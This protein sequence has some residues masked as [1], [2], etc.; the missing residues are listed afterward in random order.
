M[1]N[2]ICPN[3]IEIEEAACRAVRAVAGF[4]L[5]SA[6]CPES[7]AA[8]ATASGYPAESVCLSLAPTI[9]LVPYRPPWQRQARLRAPRP[10]WWE[11]ASKPLPLTAGLP[12]DCRK[13]PHAAQQSSA[14]SPRFP[15]CRLGWRS[16]PPAWSTLAPWPHDQRKPR[17]LMRAPVRSSHNR[18]CPHTTVA[19]PPSPQNPPRERQER[20]EH[21]VIG[22]YPVFVPAL[23]GRSAAFHQNV[24]RRS[25][26]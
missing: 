10:D 21:C 17:C 25:G 12:Q 6:N 2:P 9:R 7:Q 8:K 14:I 15:C 5:S 4:F 19:V 16:P 1:T 20:R 23:H 3:S 24:A 11:P 13:R 18:A 22:R 26:C